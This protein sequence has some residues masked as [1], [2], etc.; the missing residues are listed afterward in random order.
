[1]VQAPE[2]F[3]RVALLRHRQRAR[4]DDL[5]LHQMA[6]EEV[7]DRLSM[8]NRSFTS[9]AVVTGFPN[10]WQKIFADPKLIPDSDALDLK[11]ASC[12]L[13]IHAMCLHWANDPV[14]QII[15]CRRALRPDGLFLAILLGG[16]T[17][18]ELRTVLAETETRTTGG[19]SPRVS[20]MAEIRDL[21][22]LLQRS[23][24]ALPVAD[25]LS[26]VAHYRNLA[27]L[28]HDLREM[29]ENNALSGRL[30]QPT[31]P[32]VFEQ[33]EGLYRE[34][35]GTKDGGLPATFELICLTGWSPAETQ[36]K[37]LRPGSAQARLADALN[38][39]ETKLH[40]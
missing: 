37:P 39:T 7:Q 25:S 32:A 34:S 20:P 29:G 27:H 31:R 38:T 24:L 21:G 9:T 23:G 28:M 16:K 19:L 35:F 12:D 5:F 13:V 6:V 40:N 3:D 26:T 1:M 14:G 18:H 4:Q 11:P 30:R 2:I 10:L 17:L 15:Q 33:A 36:A 8:V 22:A